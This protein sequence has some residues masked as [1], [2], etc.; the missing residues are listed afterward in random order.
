MTHSKMCECD[1]QVKCGLFGPYDYAGS[2]CVL[3]PGLGKV[4]VFLRDH[5]TSHIPLPKQ[6]AVGEITATNAIWALLSLK[7]KLNSWD[8]WIGVRKIKKRCGIPIMDYASI[9]AV[10]NINYSKMSPM[11]NSSRLMDNVPFKEF[12][13]IQCSTPPKVSPEFC[14]TFLIFQ[15]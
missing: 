11:K 7:P 14:M 1:H 6:T 13:H 8:Y 12:L 3:T 9:F 4:N 10:K 5:N 15:I 2:Y